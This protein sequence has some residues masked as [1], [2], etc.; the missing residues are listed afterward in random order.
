MADELKQLADDLRSTWESELKPRIDQLAEESKAAGEAP[1]RPSRPSTASRTAWTSSRPRCRRPRSPRPLAQ[2]RR[3]LG[4]VKH[5]IDFLRKGR[6]ADD[7][8]DE[9]K[10]LAI[11]DDTLGGVLAPEDYIAEV[12]KGHR[13]VQPRSATSPTSARPAAPARRRPSGPATS[14]RSG[15][16]RGHPHGDHR[17]DLR[18]GGDP[19]ARALRARPDLQLGPR[20]PGRQPRGRRREAMAEQFGVAEGAA[21]V[22]GDANGKP[23]GIITNTT[24]RAGAQRRR[25]VHQRRR[26]DQARLPAQGAVLATRAG[27]STGSSLRDI[28]LLKDS[29]GNYVWQPGVAGGAGV[30]QGIPATILDHPYTICTDMPTPRPTRSRSPFGDFKRGYWVVDRIEIQTLRD[31]YSAAG[32]GQVVF[33]ARK[34][35]GGQVVL[36]EAIKLLKMA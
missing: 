36:P 20:G 11:R 13:A 5:Y 28:R 17:P 4:G 7:A 33:H 35:V 31:P 21:F 1:R 26:P 10:A 23:E 15:R 14:P 8:P 9:I 19:D 16:R 3:A 25:V 34:R 32:S 18:A 2:G 29:A 30:A 22:A 24:R 6:F 12:I 27:C